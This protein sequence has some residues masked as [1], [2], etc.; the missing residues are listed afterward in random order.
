MSIVGM[1]QCGWRGSTPVSS[2]SLPVIGETRHA[3]AA[4]PVP[5]ASAFDSG[6]YPRSLMILANRSDQAVLAFAGSPLFD[7]PGC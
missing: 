7:K 2:P 4:I 3:G 5:V 6:R 1:P